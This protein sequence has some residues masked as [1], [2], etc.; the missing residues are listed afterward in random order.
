MDNNLFDL[1]ELN[2]MLDQNLD[3]EFKEVGDRVQITDF[4]SCS[5]MNGRELDFEDDDEMTFNFITTFVVAQNR[6]TYTYDAYYKKYRQSLVIANPLTN[7]QYRISSG[8][9][10]LVWN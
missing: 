5:H 1:D 6:Q 2:N 8:H 9:V 3:P 10:K 4:S 7:K